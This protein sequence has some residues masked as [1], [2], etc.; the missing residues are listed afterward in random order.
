MP[1]EVEEIETQD[2]LDIAHRTNFRRADSNKFGFTD[3][4]PGCSAMIRGLKLQPHAEHCRRR[5]EKLL[6]DHSRIKNAQVRLSEKGRRLRGE[7]GLQ[8]ED[9]EKKP[10]L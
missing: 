1:G 9:E 5:M 8:G 7:N 10:R 3:R 2:N 4:C 6:E